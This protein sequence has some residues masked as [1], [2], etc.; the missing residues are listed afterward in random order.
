LSHKTMT[1]TASI[2]ANWYILFNSVSA[3]SK[4]SSS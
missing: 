3:S 1:G 2:P 4:S